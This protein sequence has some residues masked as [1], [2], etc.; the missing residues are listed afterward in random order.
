MKKG[1]GEEEGEE[2]ACEGGRGERS[3]R[4]VEGLTGIEELVEEKEDLQVFFF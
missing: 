4:Q 2:G 1:E 3:D